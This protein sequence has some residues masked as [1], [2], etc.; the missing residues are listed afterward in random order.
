[1]ILKIYPKYETTKAE[2]RKMAE[3]IEKLK[4]DSKNACKILK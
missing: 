2:D 4:K 1:M 3:K